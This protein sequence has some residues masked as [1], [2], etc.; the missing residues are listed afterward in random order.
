LVGL[1][2][3]GFGFVRHS[4]QQSCPACGTLR[5]VSEWTWYGLSLSETRT[6][7]NQSVA[8]FIRK[9]TGKGCTHDWDYV[10]G[11]GRGL[12]GN[13]RFSAC[14]D[15]MQCWQLVSRLERHPRLVEFLEARLAED[16]GF[17]DQLR[18]LIGADSY[19]AE[20]LDFEMELLTALAEY[21]SP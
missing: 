9:H 15:G 3:I 19:D 4:Y 7:T 10:H 12:L 1:C 21:E 16:P 13:R 6:I 8:P 5:N 2:A 18:A 14:G 11:G 20:L 17:V